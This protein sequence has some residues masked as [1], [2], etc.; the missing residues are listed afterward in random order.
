MTIKDVL[1]PLTS[2]PDPT[3][4]GTIETAILL[5]GKLGVHVSAVAFEMDIQSP[6]GLYADPVGVRGILATDRKKS[7]EN[8]R[9]LVST[10]ATLASTAGVSHDHALVHCPPLDIP[11]RLAAMARFCDLAMVPLKGGAG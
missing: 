2:Y 10:F 6:V 7:A 3:G 11:T 4:K 9:A 8:A 1:L 5:A